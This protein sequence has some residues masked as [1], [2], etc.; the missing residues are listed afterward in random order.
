MFTSTK[1]IELGSCAFRQ[2]KAKHSHCQFIH[3]YQLKA[4]FWFR[5]E[6]LDD[7]NW[8]VDFGSLK[9]LK[10]QLQ[11]IFDHTYCVAADDPAIDQFRALDAAGIIQLRV[12]EKG[13]GVERAAEK[14]FEIAS[15]FLKEKYGERCSVNQ[16]EVFEHEDN[17]AIYSNCFGCKDREIPEDGGYSEAA[18]VI[19]IHEITPLPQTE[20]TRNGGRPANVG[21]HVSTGKSDWF[22]GTS[23]G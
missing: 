7:K 11:Y 15:Q 16:V 6:E 9:E 5:C 23:W 4:K 8:A 17:S 2:W 22:K 21:S 12:F 18:D 13:V 20:T 19:T 1:V 14:C 3:G 10:K